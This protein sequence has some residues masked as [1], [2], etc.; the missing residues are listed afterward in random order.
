[1]G[2]ITVDPSQKKTVAALLGVLVVAVGV[3]IVRIEPVTVAE[4]AAQQQSQPSAERA[5]C[6]IDEPARDRSRNPFER[7]E[8]FGAEMPPDGFRLERDPLLGASREPLR[9]PE[10]E[11]LPVMG[12]SVTKQEP[13]PTGGQVDAGQPGP[14]GAGAP[15][16]PVPHGSRPDIV[17]LA[18]IKSPSGYGAVIRIN[19]SAARVVQVGDV[20][21]GGFRVTVLTEDHAALSDGRETIIAKR[22]HP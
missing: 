15:A 4:P 12:V 21:E 18:T 5:A 2:L 13:R 19:E 16:A 22:P 9:V 1:M 14:R 8:G 10:V 7:P 11:P 3:T 17:L 6:S 20:I